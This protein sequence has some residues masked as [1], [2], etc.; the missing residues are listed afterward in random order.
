MLALAILGLTLHLRRR[1]LPLVVAVLVWTFAVNGA[2]AWATAFDPPQRTVFSG[3]EHDRRWVDRQVPAGS[4][5]TQ[6]YV[7][8]ESL[9]P[10]ERWQA[11]TNGFLLTDFFNASV[12]PLFHVGG[13]L[14]TTVRIGTDGA[15]VLR[16]GLPLRANYVVAQPGARLLGRQLGEG[17]AARLVLWHVEGTVRVAGVASSA[18]LRDTVCRAER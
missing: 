13:D 2:G 3:S 9:V 8:C 7:S 18:E 16:S 6:L 14:S 11:T 12:G 15:V 4:S 5:V 17:T 1:A 10:T